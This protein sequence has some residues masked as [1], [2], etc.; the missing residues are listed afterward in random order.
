MSKR[1][2]VFE[3]QNKIAKNENF[4]LTTPSVNS[5]LKRIR[6]GVIE[7]FQKILSHFFVIQNAICLLCVCRIHL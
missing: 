4:L 3:I 1:E 2:S 7:F 5:R 6:K